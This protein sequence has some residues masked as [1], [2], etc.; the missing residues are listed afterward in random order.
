MTALEKAIQ[1]VE[2][3]TKVLNLT[4]ESTDYPNLI[5]SVPTISI[6]VGD[7]CLWCDQINNEEEELTVDWCMKEYINSLEIK[8]KAISEYKR[9]CFQ[10]R[11]ETQG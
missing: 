5:Y 4:L 3:M 9:M 1:V 8:E 11:K 7:E 6:H 2:G 10:R